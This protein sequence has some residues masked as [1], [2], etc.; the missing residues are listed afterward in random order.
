VREFVDGAQGWL[1]QHLPLVVGLVLLGFLAYCV[2]S[3]LFTWLESRGKFM[4][5]DGIV[6]NRGA[7]VEPWHEFRPLGNSLFLF[8]FLLSIVGMF[9][10]VGFGA[11]GVAIA[12]PDIQRGHFEG[13]TAAALVVSVLLLIALGITLFVIHLLL[14]NFVVPVMYL[15]RVRVLA[16]WGVVR[17]EVLHGRVGN[18]ILFF[19]MKV[20]LA[21]VTGVLVVLLTCAT[22]CLVVI[23]YLGTVILL[24][25]FVFNRCYSLCFIEQLGAG[26]R[27]FQDDSQA[28]YCSHCGRDLRG[29]VA[30]GCPKCQPPERQTPGA[31]PPPPP[32]TQ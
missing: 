23:P 9:L 7:V 12:W 17:Q 5:I 10:V 4:F 8:S 31:Q 14:E 1:Q 28:R 27:F 19:L 22:C 29:E 20:L 30:H 24:P 25:L 13:A 3:A 2:V 26:W 15:R 21:L 16:A 32:A 6:R 18:I 11:L